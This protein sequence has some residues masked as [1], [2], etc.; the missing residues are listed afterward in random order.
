MSNIDS[1][2]P[3]MITSTKTGMEIIVARIMGILRFFFIL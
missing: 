2:K 3:A 1:S